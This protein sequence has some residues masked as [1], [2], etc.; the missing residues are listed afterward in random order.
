LLSDVQA[1]LVSRPGPRVVDGLELL[2]KL[3]YPDKF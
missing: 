1:D 2:A 3:L